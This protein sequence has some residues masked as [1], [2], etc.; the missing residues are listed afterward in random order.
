MFDNYFYHERL[1]KTVAIF[2]SL[3]TKI[4]VIRTD[5]NNKVLSTVRVPLSYSPRSKFLV[6]LQQ[7][8]EFGKDDSVAI[9]L[10]RM[11]FE[12]TSIAYDSTRQ[13]A[14]TNTQLRTAS[15]NDA[16]QRAKIR[17]ST[18]YIVTFTLG[19]YANNQDDALQI[20][21]QILPYFAPQ[22]TVTM[23]PYKDYPDIKEDI[24]ITLQSVSFINE[25]EGLQEQRQTVQYVLDFEVKIDFNGPIDDGKVITKAI[26]EL[27]I[28]EGTNY[29]KTTLTPNPSTIYHDSDFGFFETYDYADISSDDSG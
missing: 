17:Q 10:P 29:L 9:K 1:R 18:P 25:G 20:V 7:I 23:K 22:Y 26:T 27:Q 15:A 8:G 24:P 5:V 2:G 4:Y 6:R 12:M 14:K 21:E 16:N 19:I 28:N 13:L 3:F 11:S